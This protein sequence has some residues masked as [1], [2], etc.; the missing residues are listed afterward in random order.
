MKHF[1]LLIC[2]EVARMFDSDKHAI[3]VWPEQARMRHLY[4]ATC[5]MV[6][7]SLVCRHQTKLKIRARDKRLS[8]FALSI[9]K[10]EKSVIGLISRIWTEDGQRWKDIA[11]LEDKVRPTSNSLS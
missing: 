7:P 11:K 6:T 3:L 2:T 9:C 10:E 4:I 8:L 1:T 5:S